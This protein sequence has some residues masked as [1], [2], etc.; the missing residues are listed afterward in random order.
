MNNKSKGETGERIAIGELAKFNIDVLLPM[1]DNLSFDFIIYYKNKLYKCQ[2][3]STFQNS[4]DS[5]GSVHFSL[6]SNNWYS[7]TEKSYTADEID[8]FILCDGKKIYLFKFDELKDKKTITIR[9]EP[10]K[11]NQIKRMT[12]ANDVELSEKRL[13]EVF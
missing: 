3:K 13:S 2:V 8:I 1:S 12:F 7:K 6:T 9:K 11:N 10:S 5:D 4:K